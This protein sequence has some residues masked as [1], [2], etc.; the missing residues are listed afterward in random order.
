VHLQIRL[1]I[2][3][4]AVEYIIWAFV[5]LLIICSGLDEF[6]IP[7]IGQVVNVVCKISEDYGKNYMLHFGNTINH[8][9]F[10]E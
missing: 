1:D 5:I 2:I 3:N 7:V 9:L 4:L 10:K 6:Q 8:G